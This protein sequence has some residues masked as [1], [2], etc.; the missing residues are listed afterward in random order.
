MNFYKKILIQHLIIYLMKKWKK[1]IVTM[2]HQIAFG[3]SAS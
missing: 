1:I 2:L 3:D